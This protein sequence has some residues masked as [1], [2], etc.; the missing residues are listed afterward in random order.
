MDAV[1][2]I[3]FCLDFIHTKDW[4][5]LAMYSTKILVDNQCDIYK[6]HNLYFFL[7]VSIAAVITILKQDSSQKVYN[8][9]QGY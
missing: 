5:E 7:S 3:I 2:S 4:R 6:V 8:G 1:V 9:L